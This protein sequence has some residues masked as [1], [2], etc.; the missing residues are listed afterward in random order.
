MGVV[1]PAGSSVF[2]DVTRALTN[3]YVTAFIACAVLMAVLSTAISLLNAVSSN[4]SQDFDFISAKGAQ[5][6]RFSQA[7]T[8]GIGLFAVGGS[9]YLG[10]IVDLLIQSYELSVCC[11]FVPVCFALFKKQCNGLSAWMALIFG[12]AGFCLTRF[13]SFELFPKEIISLFLSLMGYAFGEFWTK[14]MGCQKGVVETERRQP[15]ES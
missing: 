2:M 4:L 6:V 14:K 13:I 5:S 11:L 8:A 1:V 3:P 12:A 9:F 7:I 15:R 10:E